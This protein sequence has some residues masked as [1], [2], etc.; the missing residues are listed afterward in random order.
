MKKRIFLDIFSAS[1]IV[2]LAAAAAV[3]IAGTLY[4]LPAGILRGAVGIAV[5]ALL[6]LA[7]ALSWVLAAFESRRTTRGIDEIDLEHPKSSRVYAELSPL[8][9]KIEHQNEVIDQQIRQLREE[10]ASREE[11]RR[12]FT[13]NVSHELKTPLTTISGT[14]EILQSGTVRAEDVPHFAGNIYHEAQ[15]MTT[16]VNDILRL[17]QLEEGR[18]PAASEPLELLSL[19]R[20]SVEWL[21]DEAERKHITVTVS[22]QP[23]NIIGSRK[24]LDEMIGNLCVNAIKYNHVGGNVWVTVEKGEDNVVLSVRDNGI[25]IPKEHQERVFERFYRV[26]KSHSRELGGTGL[27]LSI[28]KHGAIY[29]NAAIEL[30]SSEDVGTNIRILF[31]TGGAQA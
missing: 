4:G 3:G 29:H 22:G 25:G 16:L 12:E 27:G 10:S 30:E 9:E 6:L 23:A 20:E 7:A 13:A 11:M 2:V 8:V 15:R 14:A 17:T 31:P 5:P 24:I 28:V 18:L 21:R 19:C 26:D 1:L